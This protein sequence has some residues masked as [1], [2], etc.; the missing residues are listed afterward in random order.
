MRALFPVAWQYKLRGLQITGSKHKKVSF[1][2]GMVSLH[3]GMVFC[4]MK[5]G[6]L[7]TLMGGYL[8]DL[9]DEGLFNVRL[10]HGA[11][12]GSNLFG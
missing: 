6:D 10:C 9:P 11:P 3:L 12:S 5:L 2:S 7:S 8:V 4:W 1:H